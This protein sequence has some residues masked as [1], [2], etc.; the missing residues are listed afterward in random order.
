MKTLS[1]FSIS[2][3]IASFRASRTVISF[4]P[5]TDAERLHRDKVGA[6]GVGENLGR[7]VGTGLHERR[8]LGAGRTILEADIVTACME[9]QLTQSG[10]DR[11]ERE[12]EI[13]L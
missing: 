4:V 5:L 2:S 10:L 8:I 9:L 11:I 7:L 13:E 3:A 6:V 12:K 1:F